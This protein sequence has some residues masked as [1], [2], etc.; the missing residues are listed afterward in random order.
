MNKVEINPKSIKINEIELRS[1]L[2]QVL[3][4]KEWKQKVLQSLHPNLPIALTIMPEA[5]AVVI[6][7]HLILFR[8]WLVQEGWTFKGESKP[9]QQVAPRTWGLL[10]LLGMVAGV[11]IWVNWPK[12]A[13]RE[14]KAHPLI[15]QKETTPDPLWPLLAAVMRG[16]LVFDRI[17][18]LAKSGRIEGFVRAEDQAEIPEWLNALT[19][20]CPTWNWTLQSLGHSQNE[21]VTYDW[22]RVVAGEPVSPQTPPSLTGLWEAA[23]VSEGVTQLQSRR[24][25]PPKRLQKIQLFTTDKGVQYALWF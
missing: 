12:D 24:Q 21:D 10:V 14:D 3:S 16:P 8:R 6:Q 19:A 7:A 18:L 17:E 22:V 1:T 20:C 2:Y 11:A 9:W 13:P 4:D 25:S 23:T 5:K 15:S